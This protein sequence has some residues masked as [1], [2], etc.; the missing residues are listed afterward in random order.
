MKNRY[1]YK[2]EGWDD[3]WIYT[4]AKR[5][6]ATYTNLDSGNYVFRLKAS[7]KDGY[8]NETGRSLKVKVLPPP[9][10]S[11]WAYLIYMGM[12][13]AMV[14]AFVANQHKKVQFERDVNR[15]L[16]QVDVLKDQF[17]ANTSHELR[18]PLNGIIGLA[19]SLMDGVAGELPQKANHNL[20]M[21]VAS[22]K[23]LSNLV[24]DILDFSKL[25][26][27]SITLHTKP[28]DI[29]ILADVVMTLSGPLVGDKKLQLINDVP[30][31]LP[32]VEADEDRVQQVLHNL[33]GNGIK[34]TESGYVTICAEIK[35]QSIQISVKD[36]G[37]GIPT[38]KLD[39]IF[40]SFE[41]IE[42]SATRVHS[43]TGLGLAVS[44][45]LVGLHGGK[46]KVEFQNGQR[47]R[48]QLHPAPV[49]WSS[50]CQRSHGRPNRIASASARRRTRNPRCHCANPSCNTT[51]TSTMNSLPIPAT[52][53]WKAYS[54]F[55]WWMM[56]PSTVRCSTTTWKCKTI[57]WW[58]RPA[59]LKP[60]RSW[61]K[62]S[63]IWCCWT[64]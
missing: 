42:D 48:I 34:F 60:S 5:R 1:A 8:W 38:N 25:K 7:N 11:W 24:N 23:R 41:Q 62:R 14:W 45:Q 13:A 52:S 59:A 54:E 50:R 56:N 43:G 3:D 21:V 44:K 49:S 51:T 29:H 17:L 10:L 53:L 9:W 47:Q 35:G 28:L 31:D 40:E 55:W 6:F 20:A 19:E 2:L 27:H 16:K 61:K 37:M 18:T 46:I 22:G 39:V 57:N 58:K 15:K 26:S 63:S 64:S 36:T 12:L 32:P 4:D 30:T 33:V